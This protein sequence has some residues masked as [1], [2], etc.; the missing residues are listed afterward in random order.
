METELPGLKEAVAEVDT[1]DMLH[2]SDSKRRRAAVFY[3]DKG[4]SGISQVNWWVYTWKFIGLNAPDQG[5]D[6]VMMTFPAAVDKMPKDC[7]PVPEDFRIDYTRS[8]QCLYN[9]YMG[10]AHR[11]KTYDP[12]MNSQECPVGPGI[13][14]KGWLNPGSTW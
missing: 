13:D 3:V 2:A 10:I 5:F 12:Y 6:L 9:P 11:D 4:S 8:G 14:H 1:D 7:V